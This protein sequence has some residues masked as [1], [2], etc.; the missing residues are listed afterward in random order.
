MIISYMIMFINMIIISMGY[1][2][3]VNVF[4]VIIFF[5]VFVIVKI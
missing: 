2:D 1:V 3:G 4:F 5:E